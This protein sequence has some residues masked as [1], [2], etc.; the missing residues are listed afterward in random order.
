MAHRAE[1]QQAVS[2]AELRHTVSEATCHLSL[3][4]SNCKVKIITLNPVLKGTET[5]L[6]RIVYV[7]AELH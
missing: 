7:I 2:A 6:G 4:F 5:T 1:P 3:R